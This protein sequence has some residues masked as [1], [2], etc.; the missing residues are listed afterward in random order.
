VSGSSRVLLHSTTG[1]EVTEEQKCQWC[2]KRA[3]T[4][5]ISTVYY[6]EKVYHAVCFD[7]LQKMAK[8]T[9]GEL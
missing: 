9:R 5:L 3:S 2:Q 7:A 4:E 1:E 6:G 8:A